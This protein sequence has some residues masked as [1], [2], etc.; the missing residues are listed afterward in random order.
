M[1]SQKS[2]YIV[3]IVVAALISLYFWT[4]TA[5]IAIANYHL[6]RKT[7]ARVIQWEVEEKGCDQFVLNAHY[8]FEIDG[9]VYHGKT[10]FAK[11]AYLNS[12]SAIAAI[13][14]KAQG[15]FRTAWFDRGNPTRSSMEKVSPKGVLLRA[16]IST[17]VLVY[18]IVFSSKKSERA[19]P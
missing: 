12:S 8:T 19:F 1:L 13:R 16:I 4:L 7:P 15:K 2:L 9:K 6:N 11:P 18:F 10:L 5:K 17:M 14:E 3:L